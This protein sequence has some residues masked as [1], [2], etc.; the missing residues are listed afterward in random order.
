MLEDE[1]YTFIIITSA[2]DRI[3]FISFIIIDQSVGRTVMG[4]D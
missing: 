3:L 2:Y 1:I 4:T